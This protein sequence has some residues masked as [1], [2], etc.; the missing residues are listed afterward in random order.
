MSNEKILIVFGPVMDP[1]GGFGIAVVSVDSEEQLK[2]IV[3]SD[4]A[5]AIGNYQMYPMRAVAKQP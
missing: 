3:A 5:N 2:Q 4:P 1:K